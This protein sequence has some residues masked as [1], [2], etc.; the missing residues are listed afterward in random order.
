LPLYDA[1]TLEDRLALALWQPRAISVLVGVFGIV[2]LVLA[3]LGVYAVVAE[4]VVQRTPEIAV[5]MA[6]GAGPAT[7]LWMVLRNGLGLVVAGTVLGAG[8]ALATSGLLRS[9]LYRVEA[10]DAA[11]FGLAMFALAGV[12]FAACLIPARRAAR[13]NPANVL[14]L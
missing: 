14:R 5:R 9:F 3:V 4:T 10:I 6:L 11:S 1:Q 8:L 2:G 13:K 12:A 7:I